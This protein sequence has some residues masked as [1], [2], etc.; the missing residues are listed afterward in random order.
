MTNETRHPITH[1][2]SRPHSHETCTQTHCHPHSSLLLEA[3]ALWVR[4]ALALPL[5]FCLQKQHT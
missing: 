3:A 5:D 4:V 2:H 1:A